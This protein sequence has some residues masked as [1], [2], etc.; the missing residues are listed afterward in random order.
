MEFK[1]AIEIVSIVIC[2]AIFIQDLKDRMISVMLFAL[3]GILQVCYF[4]FF[5]TAETN[6][7]I[8]L[9]NYLFILGQVLFLYLYF[10][11]IRKKED[12]FSQ[13]FGMGDLFM[14]L[15]MALVF[16][17]PQL[18]IYFLLSFTLGIVFAL[19]RRK[20]TSIP[21]AGIM[22]ILFCAILLIQL[23]FNHSILTQF[24]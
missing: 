22:G 3:L 1:F 6:K 8:L 4:T 15:C 23:V 14:M 11:Y 17:L 19:V 12:F 18:L 2:L 24:T 13:L 20:A 5:T 16:P 9:S 21:L 10:V 7:T